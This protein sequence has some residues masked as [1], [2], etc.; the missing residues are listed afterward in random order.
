VNV[1]PLISTKMPLEEW[2]KA[3]EMVEKKMAYKVLFTPHA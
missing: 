1:A 3:V 2:R